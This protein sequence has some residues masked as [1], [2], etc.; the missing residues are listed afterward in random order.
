MEPFDINDLEKNVKRY[1]KEIT[2]ASRTTEDE[3]TKHKLAAKTKDLIKSCF[4]T[5]NHDPPATLTTKTY[6]CDCSRPEVPAHP[7]LTLVLPTTPESDL[8]QTVACLPAL[9]R[10]ARSWMPVL[11]WDRYGSLPSD[12]VQGQG[13]RLLC[14]GYHLD[15]LARGVAGLQS[16]CRWLARKR[17]P[18][19]QLLSQD[20]ARKLGELA[21]LMNG[22]PPGL[23]PGAV[24]GSNNAPGKLQRVWGHAELYKVA[25]ARE[26][27]NVRE[28]LTRPRLEII[29]LREMALMVREELE[30]LP[31]GRDAYHGCANCVG[32]LVLI[33]GDVTDS[34]LKMQDM[35]VADINLLYISDEN[36]IARIP[37][38]VLKVE[39][40]AH[41]AQN[42]SR[43]TGEVIDRL[44]QWAKVSS[45]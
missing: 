6:P 13:K 45:Y 20:L 35:V 39:D 37:D 30:K 19:T 1:L 12:F 4:Q 18:L 23:K 33:L 44:S 41:R 8:F 14:A 36:R 24:R 10:H 17:L 27:N 3:H 28:S 43:Q 9:S 34:L 5:S 32:H 40:A 11:P 29:R 22:Q 25:I 26:R 38:K 2:A 42:L 16:T 7:P 15:E 21:Q 31:E